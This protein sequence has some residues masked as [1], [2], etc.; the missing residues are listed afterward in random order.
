[1]AGAHEIRMLSSA[2]RDYDG[3]ED[4]TEGIY[5]ELMGVKDRLLSTL[6]RYGAERGSRLCYSEAAYPYWFADTNAD[7]LCS[8]SEAVTS[9]AFASWTARLVKA[10]YNYQ[11]ATKDP[12]AFAHNAKYILELLYDSIEDLNLGLTVQVDMSRMVRGDRGHFDGSSE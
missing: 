11:L 6:Q 1:L 3:D 2:G 10:T 9:N 12:G 4:T 7:G 8:S 5:Q